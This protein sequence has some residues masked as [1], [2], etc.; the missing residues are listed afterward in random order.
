[1]PGSDTVSM[2]AHIQA[3]GE[4]GRGI[5]ERDGKKYLI[6]DVIPGERIRFRPAGRRRGRD[7]GVVEQLIESS[8]MRI[9]PRCGHFGVCGGCSLQHIAPARQMSI[10]QDRLVELLSS[11]NVTA[12]SLETPITGP[13]W[14]Y[15]RKARLGAKWVVKKGTALVGFRERR[16]NHIAVLSRCEV[17]HPSVGGQ[18]LAL[19]SLISSLDARES[20]PQVEMSV[21]GHSTALVFRHTVPLGEEDKCRLIEFSKGNDLSVFLQAGGPQTV[22]A[23]WPYDPP[24]LTYELP[25]YELVF[26]FEPLEFT[27]VNPETNALLVDRVVEWLA[28]SS[29]DR[30]LDL[31]CGLG[32]FTLPVARRGASVVGLEG[33]DNLVARARF[34][35]KQNQVSNAEFYAVDLSDKTASRFWLSQPWDKL[36][37]D[38]PRSGAAS[39]IESL[40]PR[41]HRH[42]VYVSCNPT[43]LPSDADVLVNQLGYRLVRL[44][45]VDMFPHTNHVESVSLFAADA[46]GR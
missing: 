41:E 12:R 43:S 6:D 34:N 28:P 21:G 42:I 5:V 15:R 18:I 10:K 7:E 13:G 23:L 46:T 38:P 25:E 4:D 11:V 45:V 44:S 8:S 36:L 20:I 24:K 19:R 3:L 17:L 29:T 37:L 35:S 26:E 30:V 33:N 32:N 39:I 16:N 31:F 1:M 2:E 40:S 27:Q 9:T 22:V 14:G